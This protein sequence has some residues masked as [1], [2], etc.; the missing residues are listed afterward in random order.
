MAQTYELS[1]VRF[2]PLVI[3]PPDS[4]SEVTITTQ[5]LVL[6][7]RETSTQLTC[8]AHSGFGCGYEFTNS[9]GEQLAFILQ[10]L[11]SGEFDKKIGAG[12]I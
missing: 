6:D 9:L 1:G 5:D 12:A 10:D 3:T 11:V 8:T 7:I 2:A 4:R